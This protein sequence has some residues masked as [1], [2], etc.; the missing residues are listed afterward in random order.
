MVSGL[1]HSADDG[2]PLVL[3]LWNEEQSR[4][5]TVYFDDSIPTAVKTELPD[6]NVVSTELPDGVV[7]EVVLRDTDDW[8]DLLQWLNSGA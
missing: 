8:T 4:K 6:G 5:I 7:L 1:I 2:V 3:E